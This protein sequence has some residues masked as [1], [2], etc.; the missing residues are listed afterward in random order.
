ML[1]RNLERNKKKKDKNPS[2]YGGNDLTGQCMQDRLVQHL[3]V[4]LVVSYPL[5]SNPLTIKLPPPPQQAIDIKRLIGRL[6]RAALCCLVLLLSC[7]FFP[8]WVEAS[9]D[10]AAVQTTAGLTCFTIHPPTHIPAREEVPS[11]DQLCAER[12]AVCTGVTSP[13]NPPQSCEDR[14][15]PP[16]QTCRCCAL[17]GKAPKVP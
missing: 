7:L 1:G 9:A 4:V 16:L 14:A 11:C 3:I 6:R 10:L 2:S 17:R 15:L 13:L 12:Q 5:R 8:S